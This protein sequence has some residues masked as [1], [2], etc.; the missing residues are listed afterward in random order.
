M[1]KNHKSTL[2]VLANQTQGIVSSS[3]GLQG[4]QN[5]PDNVKQNLSRFIS[6][7]QLARIKQDVRMWR[8]AVDEA[9]YAYYPQRIRMQRLYLDTDLNGHVEACANR[10]LNLTSQRDFALSS[11]NGEV[12]EDITEMFKAN[13]F[14]DFVS[15]SLDSE[16]FGY[17]L[18]A[19]GD[20]VD[21]AFPNLGPIK[22]WNVSPD[23]FNVTSYIY[24]TTGQSFLDPK[25]ADWHVYVPTPNKHGTSPCGYG[26]YYK[27]G[28]YEIFLRNL[29][30]FNGD[31]VEKYSMPFMVAKTNK[32]NEDER[33][34]LERELIAAGANSYAIIDP[35]D[36]LSFL[37]AKLAG[38]GWN[39][40]DNLEQRCEKK[41]SK[42]MLG[43]ADAM[44]S[45][46]GKLGGG[47]DGDDSPAAAAL[48]ATQSKDG[49]KIER[50]VNNLL[51]PKMRRLGFSLPDDLVFKYKNDDEAQDQRKKEDES[52]TATATVAKTM[53]EAGLEMDPSY[54]TKR[55]G[56]PATKI[57]PVIPP[58]IPGKPDDDNEVEQLPK[59][60]EKIQNKLTE[61][62]K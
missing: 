35:N 27:I 15:L 44:D 53:K 34:Q 48:S 24:A 21:D 5:L 22:R 8:A 38:T 50:I 46:P 60:S 10:R 14:D 49:K 40:Y 23:R 61:L 2:P 59:P 3:S 45:T 19:L 51:I 31:F 11:K 25:V 28:I 37:E 4:Q 18:I 41:I 9:E 39:G 33:G 58:S 1:A 56:I 54:F 26:L 17:S 47:Q 32:T 30:G 36:E 42:M 6:P 52:N 62:Y 12:Y 13:W 55:T 16:Y 20:V 29:L 7:V 43:H 57:A